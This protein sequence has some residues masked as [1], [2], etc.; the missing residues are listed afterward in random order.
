MFALRRFLELWCFVVSNIPIKFPVQ[1]W[2]FFIA[3]ATCLYCIFASWMRTEFFLMLLQNLCWNIPRNLSK[4]SSSGAA[5][6]SCF[7]KVSLLGEIEVKRAEWSQNSNFD[8][9]MPEY[10]TYPLRYSPMIL[11]YPLH[12]SMLANIWWQIIIA[13]L[14]STFSILIQSCY[15]FIRSSCAMFC[16]HIS[17]MCWSNFRREFW[18]WKCFVQVWIREMGISWRKLCGRGCLQLSHL[19][20]RFNVICWRWYLHL[21]E[22]YF[23]SALWK[24]LPLSHYF[25]TTN[26]GS[27]LKQ[28][29]S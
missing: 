6:F 12:R 16:L 1:R 13:L 9:P 8:V 17:W 18:E 2:S 5:L 15:T 23:A 29:P 14:A 20:G 22:A 21:V 25:C 19:S 27:R 3:V 24:Y 7:L 26:A 4:S 10:G 28:I 11:I